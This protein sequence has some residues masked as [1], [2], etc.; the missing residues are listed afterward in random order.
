MILY[1]FLSCISQIFIVFWKFLSCIV[2]FFHEILYCIPV[3]SKNCCGRPASGPDY[4]PVVV[5]KNW[6]PELLYIPAELFNMCLKESCFPDFW[7]VLSVV[8]YLRMLGK[9]LPLKTSTVLVSFV[10]LVKSLKNF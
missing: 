7:K 3:L 9:S 8:F 5:L 10:C 2:L 1:G 4:I 6:E